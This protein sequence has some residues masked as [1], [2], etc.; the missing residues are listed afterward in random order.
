MSAGNRTVDSI[1][2]PSNEAPPPPSLLCRPRRSFS[3]RPVFD[4]L[5]KPGFG[6]LRLRHSRPINAEPKRA[7]FLLSSLLLAPPL[8]FA[9]HAIDGER[10]PDVRHPGTIYI[11]DKFLPS[12]ISGL[13]RQIYAISRAI[14]FLRTFPQS[15]IR[16]YTLLS[17]RG[18]K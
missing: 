4:R 18:N 15:C 12:F 2:P 3:P 14:V 1:G 8:L 9:S 7:F 17:T 16:V 13:A 6:L 11:D 10:P 5:I